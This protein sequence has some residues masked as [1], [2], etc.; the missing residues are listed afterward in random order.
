MIQQTSEQYGVRCVLCLNRVKQQGDVCPQREPRYMDVGRA[1]IAYECLFQPIRASSSHKHLPGPLRFVP[2][3]HFYRKEL[4]EPLS[5][6]D[7]MMAYRFTAMS[8]KRDGSL[9][10]DYW[11]G[12]TIQVTFMT[13]TRNRGESKMGFRE[14]P[15]YSIPISNWKPVA[16]PKPTNDETT[17]S[18]SDGRY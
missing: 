7:Q 4:D 8:F 9:Q 3:V 17:G 15:E 12:Y 2:D 18:G 1:L 16:Y 5:S 13:A 11:Y 6:N 10:Q 14:E